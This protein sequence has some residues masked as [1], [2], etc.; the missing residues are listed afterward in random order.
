MGEKSQ[1]TGCTQLAVQSTCVPSVFLLF[2]PNFED[3]P[4]N[5]EE[6]NIY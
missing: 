2:R 1:L 4:T 3:T 5:D 6:R